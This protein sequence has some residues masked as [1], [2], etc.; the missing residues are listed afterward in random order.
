MVLKVKV[1]SGVDIYKLYYNEYSSQSEVYVF[2]EVILGM[3]CDY[4]VY[5]LKNWKNTDQFEQDH[6]W[7]QE[8]IRIKKSW[9]IRTNRLYSFIIVYRS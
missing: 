2:A 5:R 1:W 3:V 9:L 7:I 4:M 6:A 8:I